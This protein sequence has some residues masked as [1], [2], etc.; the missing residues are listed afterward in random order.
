MVLLLEQEDQ[1]I[2]G[3]ELGQGTF[4]IDPVTFDEELYDVAQTQPD[5]VLGPDPHSFPI[6]KVPVVM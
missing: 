3:F 2:A 6:Q 1:R 5:T 4:H